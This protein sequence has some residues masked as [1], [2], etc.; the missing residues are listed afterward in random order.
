MYFD[1]ETR[2][3]I[4][5]RST[6]FVE[7]VHALTFRKWVNDA[8]PSCRIYFIV[9]AELSNVQHHNTA[10]MNTTNLPHILM[11]PFD[12]YYWFNSTDHHIKQHFIEHN[13]ST[14]VSF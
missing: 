13:Q 14:S 8:L 10:V 5:I 12:Y 3:N 7:I 6:E 4:M 2:V 1:I 11:N 9:S